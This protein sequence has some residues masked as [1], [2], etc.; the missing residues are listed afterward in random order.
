MCCGLVRELYLMTH[1]QNRFESVFSTRIARGREI[2]CIAADNTDSTVA[3]VATCTRDNS[4]QVWSFESRTAK[5]SPISSKL[6]REDRQVVPKSLAF[7]ENTDQDL[8]VF[9]LYD[10]GMYK[11]SG[12]DS[13]TI[14]KYQLRSQIG[15]AAIDLERR[16]CVV[17]NVGKGFDIYK[18]DSGKFVK[19]LT[20]R[21]PMKTYPKG[22]AFAD[23]YHAIVGGSDHGL[24]YIFDRKTGQAITTLKH[25]GDGGV[26][27]I[28]V[29]LSTFLQKSAKTGTDFRQ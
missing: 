3:R 13:K 6:Y 14:A 7:D 22:V 11:Y 15:N 24:V 29:S 1:A 9:G 18:L 2:V 5:L 19:T 27:T 21:D 23:E 20:T 17:D 26:E 4:V 10:G 25:G 28:A 12:K 8:F 16:I